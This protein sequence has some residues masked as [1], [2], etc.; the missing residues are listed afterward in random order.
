MNSPH[1]STRKR[2]ALALLAGFL[3]GAVVVVIA[4]WHHQRAVALLLR[5]EGKEPPFYLRLSSCKVDEQSTLLPESI[6]ARLY[7]PQGRSDAP[8]IVILHGVHHLGI[9]EPRLRAFAN[10]LAQ[11]C[12]KV[13]TPT[14]SSL[15]DYRV[16]PRAIEEIGI[17]TSWLSA[18]SQRR[19]GVLGL[20]FAGGLALAAAADPRY[21]DQVGFVF[22]V[23]AHS[24]LARVA[25]FFVTGKSQL[26]DGSVQTLEPQQYG[27]LV[28]AFAHPEVFFPEKEL[29]A[30]KS[31]MRLWLIEEY[32]RART[33]GNGLSRSSNV[34]MEALFQYHIEKFRGRLL[35]EIEREKATMA[36]VSPAGRLHAIKVPVFLLHGEQDGVIPPA[37]TL[38][39]AREVPKKYLRRVLISPAVGHVDP[40]QTSLRDQWN[41]VSFLAAALRESESAAPTSNTRVEA[42]PSSR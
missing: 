1:R 20:S 40:A 10:S 28:L 12:L 8:G 5:F 19:A 14:L 26:P 3:V 17:A 35:A 7:L 39:L 13:L 36:A 32:E 4:T 38:W 42:K 6:R 9:D 27:A 34:M 15:V 16:E 11:A 33:C 37:E 22:A 29:S 18:H 25:R 2:W 30:A 24:D 21:S 41:L 23:G 31:C